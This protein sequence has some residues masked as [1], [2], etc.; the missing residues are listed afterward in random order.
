MSSFFLVDNNFDLMSWFP[1]AGPISRYDQEKLQLLESTIKE[2]EFFGGRRHIGAIATRANVLKSIDCLVKILSRPLFTNSDRYPM[3]RGNTWDSWYCGRNLGPEAIPYSDGQCGPTSGPQC[4][5]CKW[6]QNNLWEAVNFFENEA[7]H[8]RVLRIVHGNLL[9]SMQDGTDFNSR[10]KD[11]C[12]ALHMAAKKGHHESVFALIDAKA[13]INVIDNVNQSALESSGDGRC[14]ELL[15]LAGADGWTFLMVAAEKSEAKI[16]EYFQYREV[17]L[18]IHNKTAFPPWFED[19]VQANL[20]LHEMK[21]TWGEFEAF[22]ISMSEDRLTVAKTGEN[23]DY[24]CAVGSQIMEKGRFTWAVQ[25]TNVQ[26]MWIGITSALQESELGHHPSNLTCDFM[27]AFHN[28]ASPII[29]GKTPILQRPKNHRPTNQDGKGKLQEEDDDQ[30]TAR[31]SFTSGQKIEFELDMDN[32]SLKV[33]V[34][35][36]CL[37]EALEVYEAGIVPFV[38]MDYQESVTIVSRYT[39]DLKDTTSTVISPEER[40]QGF[41]NKIWDKSADASIQCLL[42]GGVIYFCFVGLH[43]VRLHSCFVGFQVTCVL[44]RQSC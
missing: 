43:D 25:V 23:P 1:C 4:A 29:S 40:R 12:T 8:P 16:Q 31:V 19:F 7:V 37:L 39:I 44:C 27:L 32:H 36:I 35:G 5:S 22:G 24:S 26:S 21:W 14:S 11:G 30:G 18:C 3:S 9:K 28:S 15:K 17:V 2:K 41:D 13:D 33:T 42:Q 38:C 20:R 6:T 34:D 10:N